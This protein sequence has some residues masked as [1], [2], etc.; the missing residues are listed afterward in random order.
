VI[1]SA[2]SDVVGTEVR[3]S[4]VAID[5][6]GGKAAISG[7]T[8]ETPGIYTKKYIFSMDD[9]AVDIEVASLGESPIV[10]NEIL[11]RQPRAFFEV[12]K[13]TFQIW[14]FC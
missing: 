10:I 2:G 13:T 5:L 14:M 8:I 1:E 7:L 9:I 3:V 12:D 4:N 6:K 11:I